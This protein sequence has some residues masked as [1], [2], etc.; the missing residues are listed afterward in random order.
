MLLTLFAFFVMI[1]FFTLGHRLHVSTMLASLVPDFG[2]SPRKFPGWW[3][4]STVLV[5]S[6]VGCWSW[7]QTQGGLMGRLGS[8]Y[9]SQGSPALY[10]IAHVGLLVGTL[11]MAWRVI[12]KENR[13]Q[14]DTVLLL[15]VLAFDGL[16]YGVVMGV[17]KYVLFLFFGMLTMWML[18]RGPRSLPK[19]TTAVVLIALMIF[20]S[21]WGVLRGTPVSVL[22]GM[23]SGVE[24]SIGPNAKLESGYLSAICDPFGG[25]C[26]VMEVFPERESFKHGGSLVVILL[27]FIPR[28]IWPEKPVG[29]GKEITRYYE[30]PFYQ[31]LGGLSMA[32]TLLGEFWVNFGWL[33]II[34]GGFLLG[35]ACRAVTTYAV[36]GMRDRRQYR[37]ARVLI[38]AVF[39]AGLGEVRADLA[40]MIL[41]WGLGGVPLV[42]ALTLF[43]LDPLPRVQESRRPAGALEGSRVHG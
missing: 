25:A 2:P 1:A 14:R 4:E 35:V 41:T 3:A 9:G 36:Q 27:G 16:F 15:A 39:I 21:A 10:T 5:A 22:L 42:L 18:R 8:A 11:L 12:N 26:K 30:G 28:A 40:A 38:P 31:Q 32:S 13:L 37:A 29:I 20:F 24:Y 34:G 6:L 33:G 17:R 7:L 19:V 43:N 23:K